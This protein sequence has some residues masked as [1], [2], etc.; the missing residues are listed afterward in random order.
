LV[1]LVL[2][3]SSSGLIEVPAMGTVTINVGD[4]QKGR[5]R[6]ENVIDCSGVK[7][8]I[9][10]SIE[11]GLKMKV[12]EKDSLYGDGNTSSRVV[13]ILK[14]LDIKTLHKKKFNDNIKK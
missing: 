12:D 1:D 7:D 13:S 8:E 9:Q 3:N 2:G 4:R 14:E 11:K 5:I 6:S 10:I